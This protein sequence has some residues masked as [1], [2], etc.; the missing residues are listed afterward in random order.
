[1]DEMGLACRRQPTTSHMKPVRVQID[2]PEPR[3]A[4]YEFLAPMANHEG[5]TDHL[6]KDWRY[7]GPDRGVGSKAT[8]TVKAAGR[9]ETVDIEVIAAEPPARIVERNIGARG[10]R[11]GTGTYTLDELPG[12][13]RGSTSNMPGRPL[14]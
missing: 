4:V 8:V 9:S 12:G 14:R 11:I 2:V 5:F 1:M 13:A 7:S 6:L 10:K 3:E